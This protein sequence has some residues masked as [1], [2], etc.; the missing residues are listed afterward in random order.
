M[1]FFQYTLH[2]TCHTLPYK[3]KCRLDIVFQ[4][5]LSILSFTQKY[6]CSARIFYSTLSQSIARPE[7]NSSLSGA[8]QEF[9]RK[10]S[11]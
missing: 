3:N 1:H 11:P 7:R 5:S 2:S 8:T 10:N 6:F 9:I 4:E